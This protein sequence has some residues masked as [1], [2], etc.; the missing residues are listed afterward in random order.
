MVEQFIVGDISSHLDFTVYLHPAKIRAL[1]LGST[2]VVSI[3]GNM[4]RTM[5]CKFSPTAA[6]NPVSSILMSR[7]VRLNLAALIG[8]IVAVQ[9]CTNCQP[10]E[11][12]LLSPIKSTVFS[13]NGDLLPLLQGSK[14]YDF[15]R[16]PVQNGMILPVYTLNRVIE[17]LVVTCSPS[18]CVCVTSSV[19]FQISGHQ[20]DRDKILQPFDTI[21]YD[22][23]GGLDEELLEIR[24]N[25]E[26]PLSRPEII[27]AIGVEVHNGI[28]IVGPSG[29]GKTMIGQVIENE[30]TAS[31]TYVPGVDLLTRPSVE[32]G[33]I[34]RKIVD[35]AI[36]KAPAIVFLDDFHLLAHEQVYDGDLVDRRL[37]FSILAAVDRL[38]G[39]KGVSVIAASQ[40]YETLPL[41]FRTTN[42][43]SRVVT[44]KKP[45]Q[46]E[47]TEIIQKLTRKCNV[48]KGHEELA[49]IL[50]GE[51]GGD[52][53]LE[54]EKV[55]LEKTLDLAEKVIQREEKL[56][57]V[58]WLSRI[59]FPDNLSED[60]RTIDFTKSDPFDELANHKAQAG[61]A[62]PGPFGGRGHNRNPPPDP[63][64]ENPNPNGDAVRAPRRVNSAA[65]P[66]ENPFGAPPSSDGEASGTDSGETGRKSAGKR[67]RRVK[68]T[69]KKQSPF[70]P[71]RG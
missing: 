17:F 8:Q 9:K 70:A 53:K 60:S 44:I 20:S 31:Y 38:L 62:T 22:S 46:R 33:L 2:D 39:A 12:V 7:A 67:R 42:R 35:R 6:S 52:L 11:T 5:V 54:I 36:A 66:V 68:G 15:H 71:G 63:F 45:G 10:A 56:I 4:G 13:L 41:E 18:D 34:L 1:R 40:E 24:M 27:D 28:M 43:F 55:I 19:Q 48:S 37:V 21:G 3:R 58:A 64:G 16:F 26:L 29:C 51:T 32:A 14:D 30:T 50:K 65:A 23:V 61:T 57:P 47:R 25:I 49:T 59:G 69:V